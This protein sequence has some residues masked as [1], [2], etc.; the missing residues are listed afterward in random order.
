MARTG[1][2]SLRRDT[3]STKEESHYLCYSSRNLKG[4]ELWSAQN[5]HKDE[6]QTRHYIHKPFS[7]GIKDLSYIFRDRISHI[8][9]WAQRPEMARKYQ[10]H[11]LNN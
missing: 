7:R 1:I 6:R 5:V 10:L 11:Y 9:E 3:L 8:P 4:H 2:N